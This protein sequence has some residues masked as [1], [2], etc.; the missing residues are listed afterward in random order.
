MRRTDPLEG[1]PVFLAVAELLSF[2]G[3]ARRLGISASAASQAVRKLEQRIGMPLLRRSTRNISLTDT[4]AEYF[5]RAGP[6]LRDLLLAT[7]DMAVRSGQPSGPLRLTMT[8]SAYDGVV[9]PLLARF[10]AAYP[11]VDV[12]I[13]VEGRLIDLVEQ[14]F[15]VGLRYGDVLARDVVAVKLL[16]A[17]QAILAAAPSY[18][19]HRAAP[20]CPADL[21]DHAAVVCRSHTTRLVRPW[22]IEADGKA[23][24]VARQP[25]PS[26]G[27]WYPKSTLWSGGLASVLPRR[28][29]SR[30]SWARARS[31]AFSPGGRRLWSRCTS[32][33]PIGGTSRRHCARSSNSFARTF[34]RS[35]PPHL[36]GAET[37]DLVPVSLNVGS[38]S[39]S[40]GWA[41]AIISRV[42]GAKR[43]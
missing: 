6:A 5:E 34:L 8:R 25:G 16:A 18:L 15:D 21:L 28:P 31:S 43:R 24:Q 27:T 20:R 11:A 36:M 4:G 13:D 17:S 38:V 33:I 26:S 41:Y 40:V 3:A 30:I 29:A 19:G 2:S 23:V 22:T 37:D 14:G 35:D 32:T 7:Q 42:M 39:Q 1:L 12:E 10:Q 9:A